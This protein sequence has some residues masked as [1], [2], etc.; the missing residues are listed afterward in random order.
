MKVAERR[1]QEGKKH[2]LEGQNTMIGILYYVRVLNK[3]KRQ[4]NKD[5]R[6]FLLFQMEC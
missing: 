5:A 4:K 6:E 3:D 1:I 2:W